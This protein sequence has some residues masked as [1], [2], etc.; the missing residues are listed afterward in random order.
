RSFVIALFVIRRPGV[1]ITIAIIVIAIMIGLVLLVADEPAGDSADCAADQCAFAGTGVGD[2][3]DQCADSSAGCAANEGAVAGVALTTDGGQ[4]E[5]SRQGRVCN[6]FRF[7]H[8][9]NL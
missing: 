4:C 2:A 6:P 3:A 7:S 1:V 5:C 8:I 9:K